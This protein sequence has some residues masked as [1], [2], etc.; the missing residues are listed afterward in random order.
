[1]VAMG[2]LPEEQ[3]FHQLKSRQEALE[4]QNA[5]AYEVVAWMANRHGGSF[6]PPSRSYVVVEPSKVVVGQEVVNLTNLQV[7]HDK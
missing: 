6:V 5:Y 3:G 4:I 1:M 2:M 7:Q